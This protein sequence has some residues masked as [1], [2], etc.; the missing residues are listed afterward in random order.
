MKQNKH[1]AIVCEPKELL[2]PSPKVTNCCKSLWVKY[3]FQKSYMTRLASNQLVSAMSRNP[4]HNP[5]PQPKVDSIGQNY[6]QEEIIHKLAVQLKNI[7]D[8]IDHRMVQED[9]QQEGR[10]ALAHFVLVFFGG[11]HVLLRFLWN[12]HLM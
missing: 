12:N 5:P 11:V 2:N 6:P 9:L 10:D 8:S 3:S 1:D 4:D 7:G